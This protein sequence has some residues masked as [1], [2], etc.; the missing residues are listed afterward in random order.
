MKKNT[1]K[2]DYPL[3]LRLLLVVVV[4]AIVITPI[5]LSARATRR[6]N[7]FKAEYL[8]TM[9]TARQNKRV[10]VT[11]DGETYKLPV[12]KASALYALLL[13]CGMGKEQKEIPEGEP[14]RLD[15]GGSASMDFWEVEIP[16]ESRERDYGVFVRYQ[17]KDGYFYQYDTD[18]LGFE[19]VVQYLQ[20]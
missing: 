11:T 18:R 5:V 2:T 6:F 14:I 17:E 12:E 3:L 8:E 4:F 7:H 20:P 1:S 15:F 16:E 19:T 10:F 13:D 9:T